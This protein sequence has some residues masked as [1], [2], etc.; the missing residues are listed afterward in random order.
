M[1]KVS[2]DTLTEL[3]FKVMPYAEQIKEWDTTDPNA[4]R[5]KWMSQSFRVSTLLGCETRRPPFLE[6][7]D[8]SILLQELLKKQYV[9]EL[10]AGNIK[11]A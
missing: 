5:F 9:A 3:I 7:S 1:D 6:G 11:D 4:I 10:I 8:I 2:K